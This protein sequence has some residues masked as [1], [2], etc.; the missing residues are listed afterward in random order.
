MARAIRRV[1]MGKVVPRS[2]GPHY[3]KDTVENLGCVSSEAVPERRLSAPK[4]DQ[5]IEIG[6]FLIRKLD[7]RYYTTTSLTLPYYLANL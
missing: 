5:R 3:P 1:A 7:C 4:G 6:P 2:A